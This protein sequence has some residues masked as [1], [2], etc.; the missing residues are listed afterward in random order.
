MRRR[1]FV[2]LL[3]C[4]AAWP[5]AA[6]AQQGT[7][8]VIGFLSTGAP[9]SD[10]FRLAA[11]RQGL[12]EAGYVEGRNFAFDY[13]WADDQYERLPA[14]AAELARR[15]VAV[16]VTGGGATS[17][18]AAKSATTT[19]PIVFVVGGDPVKSGL[20]SSLNRPDSN[21]TGVSFL[22][23]TLVAKQFE[24]LHETIPKTALIAYLVNPT[25]ANAEADTRNVL[26]AA[27]VIEQKVLVVRAQADS[28]LEAAFVTLFQQRAGALVVGSDPFFLNRRDKLVELAAR[29]KVPT[30]YFLREFASAG[31]L[32]SYGTSIAEAY[33]IVG[34][35]AGRILKGEKPAELPVQ[36][37]SK[38]ELIVNLKTAK[39]LGL[40]V[41]PQLLARAD[42]VIE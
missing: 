5:L 40:T 9:G 33:R 28:E 29:Q 32:M 19:I 4:A 41:P 16:I 37:S 15:E 6:H 27:E 7:M 3:G 25:V 10:A 34:L 8:P 23:N 11:L 18:V 20:V 14:L 21:V 35:Y 13:R 1:E 30:I 31:G 38:V 36:Q 12:V 24:I 2:A 17:T 22:A 42:E 39:A 26:A